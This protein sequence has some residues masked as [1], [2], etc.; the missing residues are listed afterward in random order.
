[1]K[2]K[3]II[4]A[5]Q[6]INWYVGNYL[7]S[8]NNVFENQDIDVPDIWIEE[9]NSLRME[10]KGQEITHKQ[11]LDLMKARGIHDKYY[12]YQKY[13]QPYCSWCNKVGAQK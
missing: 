8:P 11:F 10:L 6:A 5:E 9:I 1:M 7:L 13:E 2:T 4:P 12:K 3:P